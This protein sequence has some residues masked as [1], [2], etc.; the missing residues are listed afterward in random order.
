MRQLIKVLELTHPDALAAANDLTQ[1]SIHGSG[2]LKNKKWWRTMLLVFVVFALAAV[3]SIMVSLSFQ[4]KASVWDS[5]PLLEGHETYSV[6]IPGGDYL[7][8]CGGCKLVWKSGGVPSLSCACEKSKGFIRTTILQ[9]DSCPL[10]RNS[11]GELN[12]VN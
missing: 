7:N 12:C 2:S 8:T 9:I 4:R 11:Y 1:D 3:F 6:N 5:C 10:V